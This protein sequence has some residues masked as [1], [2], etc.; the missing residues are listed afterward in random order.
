M[1]AIR[2]YYGINKDKPQLHCNGKCH[3]AKEL[4]KAAEQGKPQSNDKKENH[5]LE[6]ET[7]FYQK[8]KTFQFLT[9]IRTSLKK[10]NFYYSD[11][12]QFTFS[13]KTFHPS[14]NFV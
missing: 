13:G 5:H 1:Y 9:F 8:L 12:Y 6:V 4:G 3:L 7:L 10:D 14:Y 2:S 11:T